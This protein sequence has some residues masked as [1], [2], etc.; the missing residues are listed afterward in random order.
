MCVC[1]CGGGGGGFVLY[2]G[3][4]IRL[5]VPSLICLRFAEEKGAGYLT[6]FVFFLLCVCLFL[7]VQ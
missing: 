2:F 6:L 7:M 5:Y 3:F 4:E 1:V